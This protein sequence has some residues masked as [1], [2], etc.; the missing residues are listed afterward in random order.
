MIFAT[1]KKG[2]MPANSKNIDAWL[3]LFRAQGVGPTRFF[4]L[5]ERFGSP[6]NVMGSS[7]AELAEIEGI[8]LKTAGQIL[9]SAHRIDADQEI[10]SARKL[11]VWM[12]HCQDERYPVLLKRIYDPPPILSVKGRLGP[13]N[14]L[15]LAIVGARGCSIYGREQAARLAHLLDSLDANAPTG[16]HER[17]P[18]TEDEGVGS[19]T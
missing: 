1:N 18:G 12:I 19:E 8:G 16:G 11:G 15:C 13:D 4:Q 2:E 10:R 7:A 3:R 14:N 9:S 17:E 6:G 5:L